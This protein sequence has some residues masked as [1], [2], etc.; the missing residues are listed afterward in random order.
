MM[1]GLAAATAGRQRAVDRLAGDHAGNRAGT[2]AEQAVAE[3][4]ATEHRA[5]DTAG[6]RA[7]RGRRMAAIFATVI[8]APARMIVTIIAGMAPAGLA[9]V[10]PVAGTIMPRATR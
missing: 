3:H 10:T 4:L 9:R 8:G 6:N 2:D 7:G 5:A 1:P